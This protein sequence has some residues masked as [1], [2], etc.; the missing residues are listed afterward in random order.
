MQ[1][2]GFDSWA[3]TSKWVAGNYNFTEYKAYVR[4]ILEYTNVIWDTTTTNNNTQIN[5]I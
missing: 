2:E 4:P 5:L 1:I 3:E